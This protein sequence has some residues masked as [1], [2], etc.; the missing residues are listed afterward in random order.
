MVTAFVLIC[1]E[2]KR[3]HETV[4]ALRTFSCASRKYGLSQPESRIGRS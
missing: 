3:A 1:V 4:K 2:D